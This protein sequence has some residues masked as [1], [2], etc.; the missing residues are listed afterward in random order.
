MHSTNSP[1]YQQYASETLWILEILC[2]EAVNFFKWQL[3]RIE[4]MIKLE[5]CE[6]NKSGKMC[7]YSKDTFPPLK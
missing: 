7:K 4:T 1:R 5:H 6:M 2:I 3:S